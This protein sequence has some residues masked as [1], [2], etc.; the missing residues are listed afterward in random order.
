[1]RRTRP[2]GTRRTR[3]GTAAAAAA[4]GGNTRVA[5]HTGRTGRKRGRWAGANTDV[6]VSRK[7]RRRWW[8][9]RDALL[10]PR[11]VHER[12]ELGRRRDGIA[13]RLVLRLF[14]RRLCLRLPPPNAAA[15]IPT[16]GLLGSDRTELA[17]CWATW[18]WTH[19]EH[20]VEHLQQLRFLSLPVPR[21]LR[22]DPRLHHLRQA[23]DP[24]RGS[25]D[26]GLEHD[27]HAAE[28]R[29]AQ[30]GVLVVG[31]AGGEADVS[32]P[33]SYCS[34]VYA[35]PCLAVRRFLMLEMAASSS[36]S[37]SLRS[38]DCDCST[39]GEPKAAAAI[40]SSSSLSSTGSEVDGEANTSSS[41]ACAAAAAAAASSSAFA[42]ALAAAA[43]ALLPRLLPWRQPP[44]PQPWR[45]RRR[46]PWQRGQQR[47][48]QP[49]PPQPWQRQPPPQ[50]LQRRQPPPQPWQRR[51]QQP[52]PQPWQR[53]RQPPPQPWQRLQPPLQSPG[54]KPWATWS[55][56]QASPRYR[57]W[58]AYRR[59]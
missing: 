39:A 27:I 57:A 54:T 46:G 18:R 7:L 44:P 53:R 33:A 28:E 29:V 38:G 10:R 19:V 51:R 52:P 43:A 34:G 9:G 8:L 35:A 42:F 21:A 16:A 56:K 24:A 1:M 49:P 31:A 26:G 20:V 55:A 11:R 3:R 32:S 14:R 37:S 59:T 41:S 23:L 13:A 4:V 25:Y 45:L 17:T 58:T 12:R 6:G 47:R 2:L 5:R 40:G 22:V 30:R 36:L 48:Q 50:P 15:R